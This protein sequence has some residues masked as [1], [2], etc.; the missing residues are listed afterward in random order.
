MRFEIHP[1]A[2]RELQELPE[3]AQEELL[4]EVESRKK[5]HNS[6]LKQRGT[7]ISYDQHGDPVHY[8]KLETTEQGYRAFFQPCGDRVIIVG[9]RPRTD[10]TYANLRDITKRDT[11]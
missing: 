9:I 8:L 5:R 11:G 2:E 3:R 7:G 1:E 6:I 4:S 10:D